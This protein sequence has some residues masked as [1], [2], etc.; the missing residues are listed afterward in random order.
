MTRTAWI[1]FW[2]S[3]CLRAASAGAQTPRNAEAALTVVNAG[4][5]G[6]VANLAEAR[7]VRV[8]FSEPMVSLG[9]IPARVQPAFFRIT[10]G[11]AGTF[12]WSGTTILIFTPDPA[13]PLP[14]ATA[15]RVTIDT[16]AAAV[17]G[18]KLAR[19]MVFTFT[20]P[21]VKLL[22]TDWYRA[23]DR[24]DGKLL[25]ALRFNQ[26]VRP[27]DVAA[28]LD[29]RRASHDWGLPDLEG[30]RARLAV[31]DTGALERFN[32]KVA[33]TIAAASSTDPVPFALAAD[34]DKKRF[35]P[36]PDLVVLE[37]RV[38]VASESWVRLVL[39]GTVPSPAGAA[40]PGTAQEYT[41]EVEPA[42][43]VD[44]VECARECNPDSANAISFRRPVRVKEFAQAASA[45]DVTAPGGQVALAKP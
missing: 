26:R 34:W 30:L 38:P 37:A 42:F 6:E 2:A 9:R 40:T 13:K 19:P 17:S 12:R 10:P 32:A 27:A 1:V 15:Y 11:I 28:H 22:S 39:D 29:P 25:V 33:Q 7:E 3:V 31:S 21:T 5:Q 18:R 16:T 20:T 45:S 35:P 8:V 23:G 41:V 14:Y 24:F 44:H 43:F 36:K 4:P